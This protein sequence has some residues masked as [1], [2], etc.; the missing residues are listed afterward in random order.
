VVGLVVESGLGLPDGETLVD[1]GRD[2]DT[3]TELITVT[4][5]GVRTTMTGG[6]WRVSTTDTGT[7]TWEVTVTVTVDDD[8]LDVCDMFWV[9]GRIWSS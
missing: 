9:A 8:M 2:G 3:V 4:A 7:W 5:A 1:G 6:A